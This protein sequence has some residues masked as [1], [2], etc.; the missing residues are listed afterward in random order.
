[1]LKNLKRTKNDKKIIKD[2]IKNLGR[3]FCTK[4][5][6]KLTSNIS[7]PDLY[8][9]ILKYEYANRT[10]EDIDK[11]LPKF[12]SLIHL[13]EYLQYQEDKKSDNYNKLMKEL[14]KISLYTKKTK[15]F[16]LKKAYE[17]FYNFYFILNGSI[18]KLNLI[19]KKEKI[20]YEEYLVYIFKMEILQE[21][22]I[23]DKCNI[24]NKSSINI[25][26]DNLNNFFEQHKEYSYTL[27]K[28]RAKN[29]LI[30][31]GFILNKKHNNELSSLDCYLNIGKF[32]INERND[33]NTPTRFFI[34]VGQYTKSK[35]LKKGDLIGDLNYNEYSEGNTYICETN[36]D[37]AYVNKLETKKSQIYKYIVQKYQKIFKNNLTNF[38]IFK[39]L[40]DKP[41]LFFEKNIYHNL[42]YKQYTKGEKIITQNSPYEGVYFILDGKINIS[43]N[44]SFN[45][46]SNTLMSLQYSIFNFKDYASKIINSVDILNEFYLKYIVNKRKNKIIKLGINNKINADILVSNEYLDNFKGS[47]NITLY[48]MCTGDILG[49]NELFDYKTELFN[50]TAT[51]V[52]DVTHLFFLSKKNFNNIVFQNLGIM[53]NVIKLI[54]LKAK[55]LIGQINSF[56][57][58]YTEQI[59]NNIKLKKNTM[60][61]NASK[62]NETKIIENS[63]NDS[64]Y[65]TSMNFAK[66]IHKK[67][68]KCRNKKTNVNLF[69]NNSLL[70]Y[71]KNEKLVRNNSISDLFNININEFLNKNHTRFLSPQ[72]CRN[73]NNANYIKYKSNHLGDGVN[74]LE[75]I[76][77][78][79]KKFDEFQRLSIFYKRDNN[80]FGLL[81]EIKSKRNKK[82]NDNMKKKFGKTLSFLDIR[83]NKYKILDNQEN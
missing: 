38:F 29:E 82:F 13:N 61:K 48:N 46:L 33:I 2:K 71:L 56:R 18:S 17:D 54:D 19:F 53:N 77:K 79:Q 63:K 66:M 70:T 36:C 43:I 3:T 50:F 1:M 52:S 7:F 26:I 15:F 22:Q 4:L 47:K 81:P 12:K 21:K 5:F 40:L 28:S 32:K 60:I 64:F 10:K 72:S 34:Y 69:K 35:T 6:I 9:F 75:D 80:Y 44:Q 68:N 37:I 27:L 73:S 16:I 39:D 41:D 55:T 49:M 30:N 78:N 58:K 8:L 20:S 65:K 74:L 25:D 24:L 67:H 42:V 31:E 11:I 83:S 59:L 14:S 45:E 23:L 57:M 51:C 62:N 76:Y